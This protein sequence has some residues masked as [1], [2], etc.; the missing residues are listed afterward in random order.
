MDLQELCKQFDTYE[1][2]EDQM[3]IDGRDFYSFSKY[4]TV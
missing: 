1:I 3:D 2:V 4:F